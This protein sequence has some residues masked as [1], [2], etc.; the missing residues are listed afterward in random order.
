MRPK[1]KLFALLA[2][3][4]AI[5]LVTATGAFTSVSATRTAEVN[6]AGDQ[7]ALLQLLPHDSANGLNGGS[8]ASSNGY[9]QLTSANGELQINLA[10]FNNVDGA[11]PNLNATTDAQGVFNITNQGTSRVYVNISDDASGNV[12]TFYNASYAPLETASPYGGLE[13]DEANGN[14]VGLDPGETLVVSI[15]VDTTL[16]QTLS[17]SD[18]LINEITIYATTD[19]NA[20]TTTPDTGPNGDN[21]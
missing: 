16:D 1:G 3:F 17:D 13:T 5:G 18:P 4:V 8:L 19:S 11:G 15:Y 6:V 10:G 20:F 12:V 7:A 14:A 9:A 21:S 2:I